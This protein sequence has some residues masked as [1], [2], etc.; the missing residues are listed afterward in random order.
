ML[1]LGFGKLDLKVGDWANLV[2]GFR[3]GGL[4]V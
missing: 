2:R 1:G 4:M 3:N